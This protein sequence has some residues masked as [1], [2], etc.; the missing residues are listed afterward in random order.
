MWIGFSVA[1]QA[2]WAQAGFVAE[3]RPNEN[4][5]EE[6]RNGYI[7]WAADFTRFN[8]SG[9]GGRDW[10]HR[11]EIFQASAG[12]WIE[13]YKVE[14]RTLP[15]SNADRIYFAF[16]DPATNTEIFKYDAPDSGDAKIR[17]ITEH[18]TLAQAGSELSASVTRLPGTPN[19]PARL[20]NIVIGSR[21]AEPTQL[22]GFTN[23]DLEIVLLRQND[24]ATY[25]AVSADGTLSLHHFKIS[26]DGA[27]GLKIW[28]KYNWTEW[29]A[30]KKIWKINHPKDW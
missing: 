24:P 22:T 26:L 17:M 8:Q 21:A 14:V 4:R 23:N 30:A 7:E 28:D 5:G 18:A 2:K 10:W 16:V 29:D 1:G 13:D 11:R 12:R 9:S 19:Q 15:G 25:K 6:K 3:R 20:S 27:N